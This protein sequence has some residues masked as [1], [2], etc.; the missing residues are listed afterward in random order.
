MHLLLWAP[1]CEIGVLQVPTSLDKTILQTCFAV[2]AEAGWLSATL[3]QLAAPS[4]QVDLQGKVMQIC[5]T[6]NSI[7][8]LGLLPFDS[9]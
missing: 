9:V 1:A 6:S 4:C 5:A 7:A 3:A 8:M 2:T